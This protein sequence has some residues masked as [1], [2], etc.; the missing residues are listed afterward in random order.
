MLLLA[1]ERR[2]LKATDWMTRVLL[3]RRRRLSLTPVLP[4]SGEYV[5][6]PGPQDYDKVSAW[7]Q[8]TAELTPEQLA[9]MAGK[10]IS[11]SRAK[12]V[13]SAGFVSAKDWWR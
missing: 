1:L 12:G 11:A 4:E 10:V 8:N 9:A 5:P 7:F 2:K 13:T 3:N 6:T